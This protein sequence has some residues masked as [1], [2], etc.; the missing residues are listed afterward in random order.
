LL[1]GSLA[2]AQLGAGSTLGYV[3]DDP[4]PFHP[5]PELRARLLHALG[6]E[7]RRETNRWEWTAGA[8]I[9]APRLSFRSVEEV[10]DEVFVAALRDSC[11]GTRDRQLES[12]RHRYG[13]DGE[14]QDHFQLLTRFAPDGSWLEIGYDGRNAPV[15]VIASGHTG[16]QPI[17]AFVGVLPSSRGR[18]YADDLL[19]RATERLARAGAETIRGDSDVLNSP[20]ANAFRRA[21][22]REFARRREL[23]LDAAAL[24]QLTR[25]GS[26]GRAHA[27]RR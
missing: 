4:H 5:Q 6:F 20:M 22:Y 12:R 7:V 19:A 8:G 9:Q 17:I 3:L 2:L 27:A 1:S 16:G 24:E 25:A 21:G 13:A 26:A 11:D 10:G 23:E 15:G 18:R 14:A